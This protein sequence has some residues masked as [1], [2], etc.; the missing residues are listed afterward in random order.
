M[1]HLKYIPNTRK[2]FTPPNRPPSPN[3]DVCVAD[4]GQDGH[5]TDTRARPDPCDA[6]SVVSAP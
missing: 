5:F 3:L 4:V 1:V 6:E 2:V